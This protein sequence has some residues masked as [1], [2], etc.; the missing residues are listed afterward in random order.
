MMY[1]IL[2]FQNLVF[3]QLPRGGPWRGKAPS[4]TSA[5]APFERL[6]R[7]NEAEQAIPRGRRP[8]TPNQEDPRRNYF[9][10]AKR[11]L[12]R[13]GLSPTPCAG[14]DYSRSMAPL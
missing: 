9:F 12:G 4:I 7:P 3:S 11:R 2:F 1:H 6:R 14:G 10:Q 5:F 8:H 13:A